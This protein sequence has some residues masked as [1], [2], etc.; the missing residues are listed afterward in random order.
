M[1][2]LKQYNPGEIIFRENDERDTA[3]IIERG[4]VVVM[5][6]MEGQDV[7]LAHLESGTFLER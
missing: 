6:Q 5:K 3:Y 4:S 7:H 1:I 2:T